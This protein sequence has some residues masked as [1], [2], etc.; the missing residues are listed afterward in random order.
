[1]LSTSHP[2][3]FIEPTHGKLCVTLHEEAPTLKV[4]GMVEKVECKFTA[5]MAECMRNFFDYCTNVQI[6]GLITRHRP[7][8]RIPERPEKREHR[9]ERRKRREIVRLWFQYAFTFVKFKKAAIRYVRERRKEREYVEKLETQEKIRSKVTANN[10]REANGGSVAVN[11]NGNGGRHNSIFSADRQRKMPGVSG[12]KLDEVVKEHNIKR[13]VPLAPQQKLGKRP[14]DGEKYLPKS[15]QNSEIEMHISS[16]SIK[17]LDEDTGLS[18]DF[19]ANS[20]VFSLSALMDEISGSLS[21]VEFF[22]TVNDQ[23]KTVQLVNSLK[24][25]VNGVGSGTEN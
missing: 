19:S 22:S 17:I 5:A 14:Y 4:V 9:K 15:I 3:T 11:G 13:T 24:K 2:S 16:C 6:W 25:P 10:A 21:V 20:T 7:F 1:M 8:A 23:N 12:I 18:I